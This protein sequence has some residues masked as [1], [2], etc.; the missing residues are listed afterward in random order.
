[1]F[2]MLL[3]IAVEPRKSDSRQ[4]RVQTLPPMWMNHA[5]KLKKFSTFCAF[6]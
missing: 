5:Q 1:M 2:D 3:Q 6:K 4:M